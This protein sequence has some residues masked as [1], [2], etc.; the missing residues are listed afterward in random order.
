MYIA[1]SVPANADYI[2]QQNALSNCGRRGHCE[3]QEYQIRQ[4]TA[5]LF[6]PILRERMENILYLQDRYHDIA[7]SSNC[8]GYSPAVQAK[9][10]FLLFH[11]F[12][13]HRCHLT[14]GR[15]LAC[16][17]LK[18]YCY[19]VKFVTHRHFL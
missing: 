18:I 12:E 3:P 1:T 16:G 10:G 6:L 7:Y 9:N 13:R 2:I 8:I 5:V 17:G 15:A 14:D 19:K 4:G 11:H